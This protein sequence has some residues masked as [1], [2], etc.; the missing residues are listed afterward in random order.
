[1]P[2]LNFFLVG[3][4]AVDGGKRVAELGHRFK[5]GDMDFAEAAKAFC[6]PLGPESVPPKEYSASEVS[7]ASFYVNGAGAQL[8]S[9]EYTFTLTHGDGKRYQGFCRWC[10]HVDDA[11]DTHA[12]RLSHAC[13]KFLPP[14][15]R[16]GS[17]LR[18]PKVR[19]R[20]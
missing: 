20:I 15:P 9:Q 8:S 16:L 11:H 2:L 13:R 4:K 12:R 1:M 19:V 14:P 3:L 18:Y 7:A 10:A 17:K 5:L 6:F